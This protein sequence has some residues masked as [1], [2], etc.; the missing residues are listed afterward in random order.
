MLMEVS[1]VNGGKLSG[2]VNGGKLSLLVSLLGALHE[3]FQHCLELL[4]QEE[5][6]NREVL[7]VRQRLRE[8]PI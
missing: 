1:D 4:L 3:S 2:D 8:L 5:A 7:G 6:L